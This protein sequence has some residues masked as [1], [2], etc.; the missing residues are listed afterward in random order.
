MK[1]AHIQGMPNNQD[2]GLF[3]RDYFNFVNNLFTFNVYYSFL[4]ILS[5][6]LSSGKISCVHPSSKKLKNSRNS[7]QISDFFN[8]NRYFLLSSFKII[9]M[10]IFEILFEEEPKNYQIIFRLFRKQGWVP[11]YLYFL[12]IF[13]NRT[14]L[15]VGLNP[16][17][18]LKD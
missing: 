3:T 12:E 15:L 16:Y 14:N 11:N 17:Q 7:G 9:V 18:H 5:W 4:T 1:W 13:Q 10:N 6:I 2:S 8:V